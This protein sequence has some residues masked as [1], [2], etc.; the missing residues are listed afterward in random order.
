L[1][2][3]IGAIE[4]DD[5]SCLSPAARQNA[6]LLSQKAR[7]R[8]WHIGVYSDDAHQTRIAPDTPL[9]SSVQTR[10]RTSLIVSVIRV[11][12]EDKRTTF[13]RLPHGQKLTATI[14]SRDVAKQLG[15]NLYQTIEVNGEATWSSKDGTLLHLRIDGIGEYS[16]ACSNPI[17]ALTELSKV[18]DGFWDKIDP[19]IYV[20]E[21]RSSEG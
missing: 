9:F 6:D 20:R 15:A 1:E 12:G 14:A 11:G 21:A 8:G 16:E 13:V 19:N 17:A 2:R 10:G 5:P 3:F 18:A 4:N 7:L